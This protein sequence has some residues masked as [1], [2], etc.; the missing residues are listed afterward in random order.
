[1]A[2]SSERMF[3][4]PVTTLPVV[5]ITT[6]SN[7][8][9]SGNC[10]VTSSSDGSGYGSI[11]LSVIIAI[12]RCVCVLLPLRAKLLL[13]TRNMAIIILTGVPLVSFLRLCVLAKYV[14]VCYFDKRTKVASMGLFVTDYATRNKQLVDFVDGIF[15]G[16][17]MAVACP[18]IVLIAT[19]ITSIR[20]WQTVAWR[21]QTSTSN[22]QK[23]LTVTKMLIFL[24]FEFLSFIFPRVLLR[25][26]PLFNGEFNAKGKYR[27]FYLACA[28]IGEVFVCM[29]SSFSFVVYYFTSTKFRYICHGLFSRQQRHEKG[30][31]VTK[32]TRE[33]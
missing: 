11:L 22:A 30:D 10:V 26:Y 9:V 1:M 23:E 29:G 15:Y 33:K 18:V 5:N 7:G 16:F 19:V 31:S 13:K 24:S 25:V 3:I 21:K 12:E 27:Y 17:I 8:N 32:Q 20:L 6:N 14:F 2:Y 28:S 4:M